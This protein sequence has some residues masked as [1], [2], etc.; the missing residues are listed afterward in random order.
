MVNDAVDKVRKAEANQG[1]KDFKKELKA[2][3][4]IFRK[5]PSNLTKSQTQQLEELDL[6]NLATGI[7]YQ[8]RLNFQQVYRSRNEVTARKNMVK[9]IGWVKRRAKKSGDLLE[10]MVKVAN[11]IERHLEGILAHWKK[12]LTTAFMEGLNSVFS[13]VKRKARGFRS[14]VYMTTMLYFVAGKLRIPA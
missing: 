6:K 11:S 4:W 1:D 3:R 5:N 12:K 9:W 2:S 10:P 7:A 14:S 8:M 13:A